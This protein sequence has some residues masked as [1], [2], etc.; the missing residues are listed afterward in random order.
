MRL[1]DALPDAL[2]G[3]GPALAPVPTISLTTPQEVVQHMLAATRPDDPSTPLEHSEVALVL[4]TSGS[5]GSPRGV[6]L[7]ASGLRALDHQVL[8]RVRPVES[9]AESRV[10][11]RVE[12][13]GAVQWIAAL[14]VTSMG[15]CNVLIRSLAAG[16]SPLFASS[17]GGMTPFTVEAFTGAVA[18]ASLDQHGR[19]NLLATSLVAAQVRRLLADPEGCAALRACQLVLVG[20]GPLPAP[21]ALAAREA[22]VTLTTTYGATETGG[23]CVF[24]GRPLASVQVRLRRPDGTYLPPLSTDAPDQPFPVSECDESGE[25]V[26]AGPMLALGYRCNP[27]ATQQSFTAA[28]YRTGDIGRWSASGTL[29]VHGRADDII[30]VRGTNVALGAVEAAISQLPEIAAVAA[31]PSGPLDDPAITVCA[32]LGNQDRDRADMPDMEAIIRT[33]VREQLGSAATPARIVFLDQLP[34]LPG[35]KIDRVSLR[36]AMT[37]QP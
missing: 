11:S 29:E 8:Q 28:G 24:D 10:E 7:S 21:V 5:T 20:G 25:I 17:I 3:H 13:V 14:P 12:P 22:G 33:Q 30:A 15:G 2:A 9:G 1:F 18:R 16:T 23:G 34:L 37:T 35:G 36:R 19:R 32:V 4:A 27:Q 31:I 26:I 6:L